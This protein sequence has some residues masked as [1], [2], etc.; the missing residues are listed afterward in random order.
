MVT[1]A[2]MIELAWQEGETLVGQGL[3]G[4]G[5]RSS[6]GLVHRGLMR[7]WMDAECSMASKDVQ[8]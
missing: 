3:M 4:I 2:W 8:D 6:S 1:Q 7:A 5:L